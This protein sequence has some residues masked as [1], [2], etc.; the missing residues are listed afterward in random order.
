MEMIIH[1][2]LHFYNSGFVFF[3]LTKPLNAPKRVMEILLVSY[4]GVYSVTIS[5]IAVQFIYRYWALFSSP[6]LRYFRGLK[7][8]VWFAYCSFFGAIWF[9]SPLSLLKM[10]A[11]SKAY[12]ENEI[13]LRYNTLISEI[14][15]M[16]F[17][18]FDPE[19][20]SINWRNVSYT[21]VITSVMASQYLTMMYCGYNMYSKME[22]KVQHFSAALKHHHRQLFKTLV[23]QL[24]FP[25][26]ATVCAFNLYPAMDSIIVLLVVT[27]Y[28]LV[29]K[30]MWNKMFRRNINSKREKSD[31]YT[32]SNGQLSLSTIRNIN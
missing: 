1:P 6:N 5:L 8:L 12:F 2:N 20:N 16:S 32:T 3:T 27:E 15:M 11:T 7:S 9:I 17:L 24:S 10:D 14:P 13:M 22:E 29:A 19:D 4:T 31:T 21:I 26:G 28:R 25:A 30:R 23:L 18:P